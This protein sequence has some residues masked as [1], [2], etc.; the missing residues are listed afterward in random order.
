LATGK[1]RARFPTKGEPFSSTQLIISADGR[2]IGY[3]GEDSLIR[4]LDSYTGKS[5]K[6]WAGHR[7]RVGSVAVSANH[8]IG[9]SGGWDGTIR[10]WDTATGK[11][12]KSPEGIG[13]WC[14][15]LGWHPDGKTLLVDSADFHYIDAD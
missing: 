15:F 2:S 8:R 9:V 4:W 14:Y 10:V 6:P 1:E 13:S 3:Y 5:L 7:N 11:A 12:L